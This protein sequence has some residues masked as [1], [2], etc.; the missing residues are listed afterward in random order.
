[1]P[2][3]VIVD[4]SR[5]DPHV[6]FAAVAKAGIVGVIHKASE[7]VGYV[8][9]LYA[10]RAPLAR[11][12][13]LYWGAYHFG[14]GMRA[15]ADQAD[16][17]LATVGLS[18]QTLVLDFE[19]NPNGPSMSLD[20][21]RAFVTRIHAR[22][23]RWP[24][25]YAGSYLREQLGNAPEPVLTRC[26]MWLAEYAPAPKRLPPQW[27]TWTLWQYTPTAG[28]APSRAPLPVSAR[29]TAASSTETRPRCG[30][31]GASAR[32]APQSR[33]RPAW[34]IRSLWTRVQG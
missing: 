30:R 1:M 22:T 9:P 18:P 26:W 17:F 12:A 13:G 21:A 14:T 11:A 7:G 27:S 5:D 31:S 2:L 25:L 16:F 15:G 34:R 29:A 20:Q 23:G 24:G 4:L 32:A 28:L 10:K 19:K 6:D 3:N 33:D 8:D